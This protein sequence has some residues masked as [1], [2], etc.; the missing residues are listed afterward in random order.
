MKNDQDSFPTDLEGWARPIMA[1]A[2][3]VTGL[4]DFIFRLAVVAAIALAWA[5]AAFNL[6]RLYGLW[7]VHPGLIWSCA[8]IAGWLP[9][10]GQ[11][12]IPW[13]RVFWMILA[14]LFVLLLG[15]LLAH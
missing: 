15:A 7:A 8:L 4:F 11:P 2:I 3:L 1:A 9:L 6:Q 12:R 13:R 5:G 14:P 10:A